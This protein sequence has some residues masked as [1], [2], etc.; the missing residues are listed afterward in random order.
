MKIKNTYTIEASKLASDLA[1][2][3]QKAR[4]ILDKY[5]DNE[6]MTAFGRGCMSTTRQMI[7]WQVWSNPAFKALIIKEY[8]RMMVV[9]V[10]TNN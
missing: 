2:Q 7:R 8:R 6:A 5:P 10:Y 3:L 1:I 9:K 4:G